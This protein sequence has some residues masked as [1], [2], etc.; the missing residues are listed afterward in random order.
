VQLV[1]TWQLEVGEKV[2]VMGTL[3]QDLRYGL[4]VLARSG[5]FTSV[6]VLSLALGI[7]ANTAIFSLIDQAVLRWLP[8]KN[9]QQL[10]QLK[11]D[12]LIS[13]YERLAARTRSFSGIFAVDEG[14]MIASVDGSSQRLIGKFVSGSYHSVMGIDAVLGRVITPQDDQPSSSFVCVLTYNYWKTRYALSP[15]ILGKT[16]TLKRIPFT[17]VGVAPDFGRAQGAD[18]LVPMVSHPLL[19]M[20]DNTTVNIIGRLKPEISEREADVELTLIYQQILMESAGSILT[21]AEHRRILEKKIQSRPAG[22]GGIY[23]FSTHLRIVAAVV[24]MVLL[25]ACANVANLLLARGTARQREIAIRL[26]IGAG[27]GR[28]VRQLLTESILL[29]VMAG[30]LG[31]LLALWGGHLL[32]ALLSEHATPISPDLRV[33]GFTA[34]VSILTGISFGLV[35]ALRATRVDL[36]P[37][38]KGGPHGSSGSSVS[39]AGARWGLGKGLVVSQIA[40]SLILLIGAGLLL[41]TV[42]NL[43][44]VDVGFD[45]EN[46]LVMWALP[47]M[48]G[49]DTSKEYSLYWQLLE[50][51]NSLPGVQS[52]SLSRLQL[53]SGF[54]AR[55]V[56]I[57]RYAPGA[58][59]DMRVSC[60]TTA[61][62]FFATMGIPLLLGRDFMPADTATAPRVAIISESMARQYFRGENPIGR[63][64]R[65]T[66]EDATGDVEIV[67]VTKDI[68][69][70]FR[71]EQYNRSPHATYIPFTQAPPTMTGQA[72]IEV[73]TTANPRDIANGMHDAAQAVD[74]NLPV[75][76]V[77]TQDEIV[78][79]SLGAKR[80][81]ARLTSFFGVLALLLASMGLYGTMSYSVVRR[82]KEIGIRMA[83]G[84]ERA[85]VLKMVLREAILLTLV[86]IGVG[87]ALGA[88]LTRLISSQLYN[89]SAADPVTFAAVSFLLVV[90]AMFASCIPAL[91]AMRL[92]PMVTLRHE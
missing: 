75:G 78:T 37:A 66:G 5:G 74:R 20:K 6:V 39:I 51:L 57:P 85:N 82:T 72:V 63:N 14:P 2:A 30:C 28:L 25:I 36:T 38:L 31:L 15:Y 67:G 84:A 26:T 3:I 4:R 71:E 46:V 10:F 29:T 9:P 47:T 48:V 76:S 43:S 17:V 54:W 62:K 73:R 33:L 58:K 88:A 35:P 56:S 68:L 8:I 50:R 22:H 91:R 24:G 77:Q 86:G 70:E 81:L 92:D 32:G 59:E 52:A 55:S 41:R 79:Q 60:N 89:L 69:T 23:R 65:F 12:F 34:V 44:N 80:S 83:F 1:S 45:R 21:P 16:I 19:A 64:F 53:F 49:Y 90:V 13:E 27:R 11:Q 61:P 40:L 87:L 18:L 42:Q 7:G